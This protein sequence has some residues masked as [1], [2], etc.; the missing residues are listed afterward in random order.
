LQEFIL[1]EANRLNLILTDFL[2]LSRLKEPHVEPVDVGAVLDKTI[3]NLQ[4]RGIPDI[5]ITMHIPPDIPV[6]ET[7]SDLLYQALLNLGINALEAV[8]STVSSTAGTLW[9]KIQDNGIGIPE[10][11][12]NQIFEPFFT[13]KE[14]GTGLGLSITHNII[15]A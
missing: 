1:E 13:T 15:Q 14:K 5:S 6:I 4:N 11:N 10:D 7:D 2:N 8:E 12:K 9:L 3:S